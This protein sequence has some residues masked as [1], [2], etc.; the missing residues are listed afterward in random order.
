MM[1]DHTIPNY[2]QRVNPI[3]Y[4]QYVPTTMPYNTI[5]QYS[6]ATVARPPVYQNNNQPL[7]FV[8]GVKEGKNYPQAPSTTI[9]MWDSEVDKFYRKSVDDRGNMIE[10]EV[11]SYTKE[12]SESS[13]ETNQNDLLAILTQQIKDLS[14]KVDSISN[15][16]NISQSIIEEDAQPQYNKKT[17]GMKHAKSNV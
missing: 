15:S 14:T 6:T 11:Y 17:G 5:P 10:F 16:S 1:I 4:P 3:A 8:N 7:I 13:E 12:T 9:T 2:P